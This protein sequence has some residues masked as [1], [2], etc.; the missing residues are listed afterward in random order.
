MDATPS[1]GVSMISEVPSNLQ[2]T[3]YDYRCMSVIKFQIKYLQLG[4]KAFDKFA[5]YGVKLPYLRANF[6]KT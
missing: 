2:L 5:L 3:L 4:N 1:F 6:S